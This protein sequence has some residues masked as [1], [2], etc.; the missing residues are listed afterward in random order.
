MRK[1]SNKIVQVVLIILALPCHLVFVL[2][3]NSH[4]WTN[5]RLLMIHGM[6]F[7]KTL[8]FSPDNQPVNCEWNPV[9]FLCVTWPAALVLMLTSFPDCQFVASGWCDNI[10]HVTQLLPPTRSGSNVTTHT[11]VFKFSKYR[12]VFIMLEQWISVCFS[13]W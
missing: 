8:T 9:R 3:P 4:P 10:Q 5:A 13:S 12:N 1:S 11:I 6:K 2:L 7:Y